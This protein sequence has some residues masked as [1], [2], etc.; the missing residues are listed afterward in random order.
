MCDVCAVYA[1]S[2]VWTV[3]NV[4]CVHASRGVCAVLLFA[5]PSKVEMPWTREHKQYAVGK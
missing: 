3:C 4:Q 1:A 2:A 5:E